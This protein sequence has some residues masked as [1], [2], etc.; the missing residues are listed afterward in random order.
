MNL[1]TYL[2]LVTLGFIVYAECSVGNLLFRMD[3]RGSHALNLGSLVNFMVH[4]LHNRTLWHLKT[5]DINYP[6]VIL[7]SLVIYYILG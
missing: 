4:P 1:G 3:S 5:L 2:L 7:V 6:F